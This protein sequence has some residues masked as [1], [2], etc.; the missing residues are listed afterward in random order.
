MSLEK[1]EHVD[2][3]TKA[4]DGRENGIDLLMLDHGATTDED[5]RFRLLNQKLGTYVAYVMDDKFREA[6]P[7]TKPKDVLIRVLCKNPPTADMQIVEAVTPHGDW[8]NEIRVVFEDLD[9]FRKQL[10]SQPV[11]QAQP[12]PPKKSRWPFRR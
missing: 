1:T 5:E 8:V 4:L 9:E 2:L 10:K 7:Q 3:V 12:E 11:P 6:H